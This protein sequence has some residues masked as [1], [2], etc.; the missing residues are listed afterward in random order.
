V[1]D[2]ATPL[3]RVPRTA[4]DELILELLPRMQQSDNGRA[5]VYDE[6][7][8]VGIVSPS[9]ITRAMTLAGLSDQ[10]RAA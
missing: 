4:P 5:L 10:P 8:L 9:D 3:D 1:N 7:R 2:I 6:G